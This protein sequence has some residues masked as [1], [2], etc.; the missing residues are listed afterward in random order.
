LGLISGKRMVSKKGLSAVITTLLIILL[1]IVA[2]GIVSVVYIRVVENFSK[3]IESGADC[4][5]VSININSVGCSEVDINS[6]GNDDASDCSVKVERRDS[7]GKIGGVKVVFT[8]TETEEN[9]N[10]IDFPGDLS[11][12]VA[13]TLDGND[14]SEM[15][16]IGLTGIDL[17]T[18]VPYFGSGSDVKLCTNSKVTREF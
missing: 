16:G 15:N 6:D 14:N 8:S 1:V 18:V 2:L 7:S 4:F 10:E 9:S 5:G 11:S 13:T 3:D 17:V 12:L